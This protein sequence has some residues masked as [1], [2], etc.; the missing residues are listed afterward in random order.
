MTDLSH[1][2][3]GDLMDEMDKR[4]REM[5]ALLNFRC[6]DC[7]AFATLLRCPSCQKGRGE[8]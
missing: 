2:S 5:D 1:A 4:T 6:V 7:G 8:K 3:F